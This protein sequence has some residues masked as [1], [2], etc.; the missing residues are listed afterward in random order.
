M[1]RLCP[2]CRG[3]Q[4]NNVFARILSRDCELCGGKGIVDTDSVCGCGRPCVR[5]LNG[6]EI[7]TRWEC[8]KAVL[9]AAKSHAV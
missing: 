1:L 5:K 3:R 7:C 2:L 8:E 6:I 4:P 9:D